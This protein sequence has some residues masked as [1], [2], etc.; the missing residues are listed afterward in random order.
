MTAISLPGLALDGALPLDAGVWRPLASL[1]S[2]DLSSNKLTGFV[3]PQLNALKD[4]EIVSLMG[5]GLQGPLPGGLGSL[6]KL[7]NLIL[8]R[9]NLTG[10]LPADWGN[11]TTLR[12]VDVSS[13]ALSGALPAGW[14]ALASLRLLN[15]SNND[16]AGPLPP[17]WRPANGIGGMEALKEA[18]LGG[19]QGLCAKGG[20]KSEGF[21]AP[22]FYNPPCSPAGAVDAVPAKRAREPRLVDNQGTSAGIDPNK[23]KQTESAEKGAKIAVLPPPP[24]TNATQG[25]AVINILP[26]G[27]ALPPGATPVFR[28]GGLAAGAPVAPPP[29]KPTT[30][31]A[32]P[33]PAA[34]VEAELAKKAEPAAAP[35][36]TQA[37]TPPPPPPPQ[38]VTLDLGPAVTRDAV[39]GREAD[40]AAALAKLAGVPADSLAVS[41]GGRAAAS[42][43]RRLLARRLAQTPGAAAP[44]PAEEPLT[45]TANFSGPDAAAAAARLRAALKSGA[46]AAALSQ[47]G[48][49]LA[50]PPTGPTGVLQPRR[51]LKV[52][53]IVVGAAAGLVLLST[54]A[55]LGCRA[56]RKAASARA[57]DR[58]LYS[59]KAN[60]IFEGDAAERGG[61]GAHGRA[62]GAA[63][64]GAPPPAGRRGDDYEVVPGAAAGAR[65]SPAKGGGWFG[66]KRARRD[67]DDAFRSPAASRSASFQSAR[68]HDTFATARS[69]AAASLTDAPAGRAPARGP[70][71]SA[72]A[73]VAGL[74]S[75]PLR[76]ATRGRARQASSPQSRPLAAGGLSPAAGSP[77]GSPPPDGRARP[78]L[79]A[80]LEAAAERRRARKA[81]RAA[82]AGAA[83]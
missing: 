2:V 25:D 10:P 12:V 37:A 15:V 57:A 70:V 5:N 48:L 30:A 60:P 65:P 39:A 24:G 40:V 38:A 17:A 47:L 43:R 8:A 22:D 42:G 61:A 29:A 20:N 32:A 74:V 23:L 77:V 68:S 26:A 79:A 73:A 55:A 36:A 46:L 64:A 71:A 78:T 6:P 58:T 33:A 7:E 72:A 67:D 9:N 14:A 54:L 3:P 1:K 19:N 53:G 45:L 81:Q 4:A 52:A 50:P 59:H 34:P 56:G 21:A 80:R 49:D 41:V 18:A 82:D 51:G 75:A 69:D 35:A 63:A 44:A 27:A 16:L 76:A 13:N 66:S 62:A 31:K 83:A 11:A 28:G